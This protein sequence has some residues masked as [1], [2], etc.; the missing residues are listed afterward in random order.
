MS[1]LIKEIKQQPEIL[2]KILETE[3]ENIKKL[4]KEIAKRKIK[5]IVLAARGSSDNACLYGKYLF[6]SIC[7]L[8]VCLSTPSLF[9][10]YKT[11]PVMKDSLVIGI[12]QSG[13]SPDI[14]SVIEE[15][16]KQ[17]VLTASITNDVSS[18]LAA[19]S[20]YILN[21]HSGKEK[22]IAATKTYTSQL[23]ILAIL[24]AVYSNKKN[25]LIDLNSLPELIYK[26][27][28]KEKEICQKVER[29]R[30]LESC[31]IIGRGYN[32]AT[33]HEISLK[34]KELNHIIA[35]PY[36]S[37]DFMHGPFALIEQGFPVMMI[38]PNGMVYDDLMIFVKKLKE[39]MAELIVI[40]DKDE[41]LD[42]ANTAIKLPENVPEWLS[43]ITSVIP[44]QL[45]AYYLTITKGFDPDKP[46]S[47]KKVTK[48]R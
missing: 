43:P 12:S 33:A 6:G 13:Q 15:A 40:S 19:S 38:V 26:T 48:T 41:A 21:C 3:T 8:P 1:F 36:S 2:Q 46:R 20:H 27:L 39:N 44:G 28:E 34:L 5:Y 37:A 11:P 42:E 9:T 24:A 47:L 31:A 23:M 45:F 30:Y 32:Y 4:A 35:E 7:R 14:I 16:N 22:S 25:S 17:G 29:Y 10:I 18:P